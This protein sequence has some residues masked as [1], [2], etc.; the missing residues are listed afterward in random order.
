MKGLI[1]DFGGVLTDRG[2]DGVGEPPLIGAVRSARAAG[3]R[4]ALLSNA[5]G[6]GEPIPWLDA[7]FDI[8]VFSGDVGVAKPDPAI[9]RLTVERLGLQPGE[10][11]FV[12]DLAVNIRGAAATGLVGIHHTSVAS[13]LAELSALF[14]DW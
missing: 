7:L 8:L 6:P 10:C 14:G 9:Y 13:T 2:P 11:A 3:I 4:T 5:D 12:D 1:V